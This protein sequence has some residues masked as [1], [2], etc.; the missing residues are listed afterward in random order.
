MDDLIIIKADERGVEKRRYSG[1]ILSINVN[2][3]LIEAFF[4]YPDLPFH[5][6][7]MQTGDLFLE[8]YYLDRWYNIFEMYD[9]NGGRL[10][11]WYCNVTLPAELDGGVLTY[12]DLALDLLVF[13]DGRQII[14]DVDEFDRM[15]VSPE[16]KHKALA[17]LKELQA[18]FTPPARFLLKNQI[19]IL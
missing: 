7:T 10:K 8:M 18:L 4:N 15:V 3:V 11:G 2:Y 16:I 17:T 12:R 13:P 1:R 9:A 5:G 19:P 6:I 14:L